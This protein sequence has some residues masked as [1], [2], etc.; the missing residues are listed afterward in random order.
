MTNKFFKYI[1][2]FLVFT[3]ASV[4]SLGC[5]NTDLKSQEQNTLEVVE[6]ET[7]SEPSLVTEASAEISTDETVR[8]DAHNI[9]GG[10]IGETEIRMRITRTDHALSA[11]YITRT[12]DE[13]FFE[14]EMTSLSE[15]EL[16]D[17]EGG[18]L[19]CSLHDGSINGIGTISAEDVTIALNLHTFFPIGYDYDDYYSGLDHF[20]GSSKEVEAFVQHIK[21]SIDNKEEF[22]KLFEYPL[23]I[24]IEGKAT[25]IENENDMADQYDILMKETDFREQIKNIFTKYLFVTPDGGCVENGIIW[26][27]VVDS[28]IFKI[29]AVNYRA[30]E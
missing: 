23:V 7:V 4:I 5:S 9:F 10:V 21:D 3:V 17:G 2:I 14:G 18:Y 29:W 28:N 15:F 6:K 1:M 12:N 22:L 25:A 30:S 26:F 8:N 19:K 24:R 13:K 16:N 11:A 20:G 27:R